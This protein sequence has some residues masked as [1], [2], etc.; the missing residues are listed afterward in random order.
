MRC[1]TVDFWFLLDLVASLSE[2]RAAVRAGDLAVSQQDSSQ[3]QPAAE[4]KKESQ[5][6]DQSADVPVSGHSDAPETHHDVPHQAAQV[7]EKPEEPKEESVQVVDSHAVSAT[8]VTTEP[9]QSSV[10]GPVD[11]SETKA[12]PQQVDSDTTVPAAPIG[13]VSHVESSPSQTTESV[14]AVAALTAAPEPSADVIEASKSQS[15]LD[16]AAV[17][18]PSRAG[19]TEVNTVAVAQHDKVD[20]TVAA[21]VTEPSVTPADIVGVASA[22]ITE[23]PVVADAQPPTETSTADSTAPTAEEKPADPALAVEQPPPPPA[24][25]N[26][27]LQRRVRLVLLS[28]IVSHVHS[29]GFAQTVTVIRNAGAVD[30]SDW[31]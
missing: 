9:V 11:S 29:V 20:L 7:V 8:P 27:L 28:A 26:P 5:H 24:K 17:E 4:A 22:P 16:S 19:Q 10:A 3:P 30:S 18:K 25:S 13:V 12:L 2:L 31:L 14:S 1:A 15:E 21:K 6:S 23:E